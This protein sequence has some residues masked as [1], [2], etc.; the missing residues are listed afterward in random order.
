MKVLL[1]G[2]T[3]M[4]GHG[5]LQACAVDPDVTEVVAIVRAPTGSARPRVREVASLDVRDLSSIASELAGFDACFFTLGVSA[6]GMS[7]GA[8]S[9]ITYDLTL[10]IAETL[11]QANP[12]MTFIYVSGA[13]TDSSEKGRAMWARVKGRTE[14]ALLALPF[15]AAFMFR[16]GFIQPLPGA[17]SKTRLYR[18]I[19]NVTAPLFPLLR[20]L[21]PGHIVNTEEVGRAMIAVTRDGYP[22][23]ILEAADIAAVARA[24]RA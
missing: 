15:R 14:N 4:I 9:A 16:P 23:R 18:W 19:Y 7:E 10:S 8:Y 13:S 3:G 20:A 24:D 5:V 21:F 12:R 6:V 17:R 22:K 1:F 11:V 2:S